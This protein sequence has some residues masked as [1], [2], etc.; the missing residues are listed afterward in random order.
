MPQ[1]TGVS[2]HEPS[3]DAARPHLDDLHLPRHLP[4]VPFTSSLAHWD[5]HWFVW[6]PRHPV[7]ECVEIMSRDETEE[8]S[9]FVWVFF[10]ER[11]GVKRQRHYVNQAAAAARSSIGS[12]YRPIDYRRY[13]KAN[14][15]QSVSVRFYD[16]DEQLVTIDIVLDDTQPLQPAGL[17]DQSGHAVTQHFLI[18]F[19]ALQALAVRNRVLIAGADFSFLGE[20]APYRFQA[21]YSANTYV[22]SIPFRTTQFSVASMQLANAAG[23]VFGKTQ[24]TLRGTCYTSHSTRHHDQV[25]ICTTPYGGLRTYSHHKGAHRFDLHV[26]PSLDMPQEGAPGVATYRMGLAA[27]PDLVTGQVHCQRSSHQMILEW[28]HAHPQWAQAYGF[29]SIIT[30]TTPDAYELAVR[31]LR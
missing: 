25:H 24:T 23:Y 6:L 7:Y 31:P 22:V 30:A 16:V 17:T 18:F 9:P 27:H 2:L 20:T 14:G 3:H 10:T 13:G 8:A 4:L 5:H 28:R 29:T 19:R 1:S 11:A 12:L 21:A 15:A 26:Q